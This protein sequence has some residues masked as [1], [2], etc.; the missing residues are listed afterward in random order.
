LKQ[1]KPVN[2]WIQL[3]GIPMQMGITIYLF[4]FLG[5]W[6]DIKYPNNNQIYTKAITVLGV[7]ISLYLV[8]QQVNRINKN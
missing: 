4:A 7:F 2:K 1:N 5:Q 6:L 8:I 3:I